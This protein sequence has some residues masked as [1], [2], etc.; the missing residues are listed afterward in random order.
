MTELVPPCVILNE[1]QLA[2]N[3]GAVARVMANF[4]LSDLRL[5]RPRDGWPQ[6][7]AWASASGANWPLDGAKVFERIEDAIAD[8]RLLYATTARPRET[9]LPVITPREAAANLYDASAEGLGV[10]L[11]FGGERAGL[12][13]HDIALSQGIVT[14]PIDPKFHSLNLAQA[15][16]VN[17]YEWRTRVLDAPPPR[18]REGP[19][20]ADQA[21]MIGLYEQLE[22]ELDEAGFFHPPEKRP[23]M[24]RNLRVALS[25][26]RFS[27]QEVR[28]F[29][30][31]V[32]ALSRGRGRVLAKLAAAKEAQKPQG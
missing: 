6:E 19:P 21:M 20:P 28:T 15:V 23:S 18:F 4:G 13:T 8:L 30:G 9:Q 16:A 32:T 14:I 26:A 5:V 24:V 17:A 25:R 29:R 12:E 10:G 27:D 1:P 11:L 3:I 22:H 2:E 31:V 7:R